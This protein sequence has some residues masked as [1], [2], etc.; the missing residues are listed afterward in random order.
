MASTKFLDDNGLLYYNQK[1]QGQLDTKLN[2]TQDIAQGGKYL[3][4]N[5]TSGL[6]EPRAIDLSNYVEKLTDPDIVYGTDETGEQT[7]YPLDYFGAIDVVLVDG[8]SVVT[9]KV[10]EIDLEDRKSVV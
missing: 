5:E 8:T 1:I 10:A 6:L 4:I 2:K 3:A 9:D 7:S